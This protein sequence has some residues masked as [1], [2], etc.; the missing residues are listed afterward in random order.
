MLQLC[1]GR[2][3]RIY[4]IT[5]LLGMASVERATSLM[6][7]KSSLYVRAFSCNLMTNEIWVISE[8]QIGGN[9][10]M[11]IALRL[12]VLFAAVGIGIQNFELP[13]PPLPVPGAQAR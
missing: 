13:A 9:Q 3:Y 1:C 7:V 5:S 8:E 4:I 12:L 10:V 2:T 6:P 11:K